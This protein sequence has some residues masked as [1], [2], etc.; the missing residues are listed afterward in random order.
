[1]NKKVELILNELIQIY[2]NITEPISS[3]KLKELAHLPYSAS[4]IRSYFK[5]LEEYELIEKEHFSSGSY[6]S[7]KAMRTFWRD[8]LSNKIVDEDIDLEKKA[9]E[10][11]IYILIEMFE[12][13]LLVEVYNLNNKFIILEFEKDEVIFKYDSNLY[14]L[15]K[16]LKGMLL[17]ELKKYLLH[18]G[19]I[20]EYEH[21][22][23]LY[24]L[25]ELNKKF[26]YKEN[27]ENEFES[28]EVDKISNG[29][30]FFEN[31]VVF[32]TLQSN[33]NMFKHFILLG[34]VYT[35]FLSIVKPMKG[36]D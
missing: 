13:Q 17:D 35:D 28:V 18:I 26:I 16:S 2:L 6:P 31:Y 24:A 33:E 8:V 4:S 3:T 20:R 36:G 30:S 22:K 11:D 1:M 29:I 15:L 19:L 25:R 32:K 14:N 27:L 34:N 21:I 9:K 7:V 10:L 23:T 5:K 12:N